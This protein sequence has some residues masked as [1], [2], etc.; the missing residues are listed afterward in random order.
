[1]DD[2]ELEKV[3]EQLYTAKENL[4]ELR[5]TLNTLSLVEKMSKVADLKIL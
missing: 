1:M 3:V 5:N 4:T 2:E